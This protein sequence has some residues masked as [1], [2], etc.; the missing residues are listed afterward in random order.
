LKEKVM[1]KEIVKIANSYLGQTEISG[2]RGF[3]NKDF[4]KKMREVGFYTGA[5]W[6]MFF[7]RWVWKEAGI[8]FDRISPSS[9]STMRNATKDKTWFAEPKIGSIAIFR[10]FVNGKPQATG[11]GAIVVSV[12]EGIYSTV[13]GNTNDK[14]G[15]EGIMVAVR[16]RHLN[17]D[18]WT[19]NNGLR[20]MGFVHY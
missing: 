12:G 8:K 15:R 11:H 4:E 13:D 14:G 7:C 9:V 2:N 10:T 16:N 19:K 20:L 5:P 3:I 6:C 17:A 18:S 1:E